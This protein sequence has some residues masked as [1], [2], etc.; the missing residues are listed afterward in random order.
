MEYLTK[1]SD[2]D[3]QTRS[4]HSPLLP[5]LII[6]RSLKWS[7]K[8][9]EMLSNLARAVEPYLGSR[10]YQVIRLAPELE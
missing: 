4:R 7:D 9:A 10:E 2:P 8:N 6:V 3:C 5:I 1:G